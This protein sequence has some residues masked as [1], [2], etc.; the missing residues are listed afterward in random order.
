MGVIFA[1]LNIPD[2]VRVFLHSLSLEKALS[3]GLGQGGY[4]IVGVI[5]FAIMGY[6]LYRTG[7]AKEE[8]EVLERS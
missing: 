3:G 7:L 8:P 1:F 6:A 5:C 2:K 4:Y